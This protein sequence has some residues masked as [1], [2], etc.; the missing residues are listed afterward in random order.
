MHSPLCQIGRTPAASQLV[1]L[2]AEPRHVW[3]VALQ[4]RHTPR[5]ESVL[6]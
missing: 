5:P 1:Q 2:V 3:Q 4:L 6:R